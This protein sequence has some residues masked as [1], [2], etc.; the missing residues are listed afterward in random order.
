MNHADVVRA[1]MQAEID[2]LTAHL[3][4]SPPSGFASRLT[5][6]QGESRV[7]AIQSELNGL[8]SDVFEMAFSEQASYAKHSLSTTVLSNLLSRFQRAITFAGWA[9]LAGPGVHGTPPALVARAFETE[10]NAFAPGSFSVALSP[11]ESAIEH[12]QL[13]GA[14]SD[15]LT[16][17][18]AGLSTDADVNASD[19]LAELAQALGAEATRRFALFFAKVHESQLEARFEM[20]SLPEFSVALQPDEALR[21]ASWLKNVE[22]RFDLLTVTGALTA[23]DSN[24]GRFAITDELGEIHDGKAA[25]ELLSRATIDNLYVARMRVTTLTSTTTSV[26]RR[27]AVLEALEP[28]DAD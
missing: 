18:A 8:G 12:E 13:E 20:K 9:R 14:L 19:Q 17:A 2:D 5:R 28:V 4:A 1:Q 15:F 23:A 26:T 10:V 3:R 22:Q 7:E 24:A 27:R 11:Y 25:P 21:V 6:M 16:L